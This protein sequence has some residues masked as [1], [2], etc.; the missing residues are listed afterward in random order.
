[1]SLQATAEDLRHQFYDPK[2][3]DIKNRA[4]PP[5]YAPVPAG[6]LVKDLDILWSRKWDQWTYTAAAGVTASEDMYYRKT[7]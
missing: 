7:E 6:A 5:G 1:M 2:G 3:F 4:V